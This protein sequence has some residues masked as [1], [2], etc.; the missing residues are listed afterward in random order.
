MNGLKDHISIHPDYSNG[1]VLSFAPSPVV[2]ENEEIWNIILTAAREQRTIRIH[3]RSLRSKRSGG[4]NVD[5]YHILNMQGDWYLFAYDHGHQKVTSRS[6]G[7]EISFPVSAADVS[8]LEP[9]E[10][11]DI[12]KKEVKQ[13]AKV[14]REK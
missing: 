2:P 6:E 8:I 9:K 5:P 1:G 4:R 7:F 13:M 3:Y 14:L 12:V 10:L 11:K